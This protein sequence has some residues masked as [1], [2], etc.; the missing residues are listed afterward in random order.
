MP[1]DIISNTICTNQTLPILYRDPI[2]NG[3]NGGTLALLDLASKYTWPKQAAPVSGDSLKNLTESGQ[4]GAVFLNGGQ[5]LSYAGRGFDFTAI[6]DKPNGIMLPVSASANLWGAGSGLQY[7]AF[8]LYMKLPASG[9]WPIAGIT[10]TTIVSASTTAN[11]YQSSADLLSINMSG[12]GGNKTLTLNRQTGTGG[13]NNQMVVTPAVG[14]F[15]TLAQLLF[16]RNASGQAF[17]LRTANGDKS[18]TFSVQT[19]NTQDFSALA[20]RL[21][22]LTPFTTFAGNAAFQK[23]RMYRA[24]L[25]NLATSGRDPVAVANADWARVIASGKFS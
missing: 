19:A 12:A 22:I 23:L 24:W 1:V 7:F 3:S 10:P 16:Y 14:D 8:M 17:R 18:A 25:E 15:G 5:A 21:G 9:D 2:L 4:D 6:S 13:A 20:L 11:G